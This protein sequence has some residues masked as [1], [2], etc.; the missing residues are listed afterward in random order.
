MKK[1]NQGTD[2]QARIAELETENGQLRERLDHEV[3]ENERQHEEMMLLFETF[4]EI[5]GQLA[6]EIA[7]LRKE[8]EN[9][10]G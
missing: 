4:S 5:H 6:A 7:R 1:Q 10:K 8:L 3:S 2:F 9:G